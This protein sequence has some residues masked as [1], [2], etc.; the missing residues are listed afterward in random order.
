LKNK[1]KKYNSE[2]RKKEPSWPKRDRLRQA[3]DVIWRF[4]GMCKLQLDL[5]YVV[6]M[7][8]PSKHHINKILSLQY[9]DKEAIE[10]VYGKK[11][12]DQALKLVSA[13][14]HYVA[15]TREFND[16]VLEKKKQEKT[17]K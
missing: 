17:G 11:L 4:Q 2:A 8:F 14:K 1:K 3:V 7:D 15:F 5:G 9:M 10:S 12:A 16:D 6:T 13:C